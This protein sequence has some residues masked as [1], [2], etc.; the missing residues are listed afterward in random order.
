MKKKENKTKVESSSLRESIRDQKYPKGFMR[1]DFPEISEAGL[2]HIKHLEKP[3]PIY[4]GAPSVNNW[5]RIKGTRC[6]VRAMEPA[7]ERTA[8]QESEEANSKTKQRS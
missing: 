2:A 6:V 3:I 1:P 5:A 4:S 8:Q 7:A